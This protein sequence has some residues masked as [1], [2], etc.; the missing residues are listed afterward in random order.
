MTIPGLY[1]HS[2]MIGIM[3]I[4]IS[5]AASGPPRG[6]FSSDPAPAGS[7]RSARAFSFAI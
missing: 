7:P 1:L 3:R 6:F 4:A 2:S 5:L